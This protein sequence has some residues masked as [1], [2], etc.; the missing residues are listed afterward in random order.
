[1]DESDQKARWQ[2]VVPVEKRQE[3]LQL[4]HDLPAAGHIGQHKTIEQV[5]QGVFWPGLKRD[6]RHY[7]QECDA[8]TAWKLPEGAPR[9]PLKV[10]VTGTP[11]TCVSV[12]LTGPLPATCNGKGYIL[13]MADHFEKWCECVALPNQEA[14]I[15]SRA[16]AEKWICCWGVP[17]R[18]H[19][20]QG[21]QFALLLFRM[22]WSGLE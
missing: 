19:S 21:Q 5:R 14:G 17:F 11:S 1:M 4:N 20:N 7:Y 15:I 6:V 13:V 8:C 18:F 16:V 3:V 22:S 12:D 10:F 2:L 9:V